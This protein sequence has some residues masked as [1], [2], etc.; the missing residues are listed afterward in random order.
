[1]KIYPVPA[2]GNS[3]ALKWS[4]PIEGAHY[5]MV[6]ALGREM[7]KG[8]LNAPSVVLDL[9]SILPGVYHVIVDLNGQQVSKVFLRQ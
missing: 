7:L 5:I 6:D 2:A 3:V 8:S 1:M 4:G 9:E